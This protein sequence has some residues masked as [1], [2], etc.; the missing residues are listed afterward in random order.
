MNYLP[1]HPTPTGG[2][3]RFEP[4]LKADLYTPSFPLSLRVS[5]GWV[6]EKIL[7][8]FSEGRLALGELLV[9]GVVNYV[10]E[11]G[12]EGVRMRVLRQRVGEE[13]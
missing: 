7:A 8:D 6:A 2:M 13:I 9:Y 12:D 5:D 10:Y 11:V 4:G 3:T 1:P